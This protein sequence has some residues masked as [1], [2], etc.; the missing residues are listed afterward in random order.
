MKKGKPRTDLPFINIEKFKLFFNGVFCV[1]DSSAGSSSYV[2]DSSAVLCSYVCDSSAGVCS[3]VCSSAGSCSYVYGSAGVYGSGV[4]V[5]V[6]HHQPWHNSRP[7]I[8]ERQVLHRLRHLHFHLHFHLL[9]V[10]QTL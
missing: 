7:S 9:R 10:Y 3:Y 8:L 1:C 2:C 5:Y 4:C 6:C